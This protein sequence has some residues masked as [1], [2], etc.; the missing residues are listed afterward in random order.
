MAIRF[1]ITGGTWSSTSTWNDGATLG[2]PTSADDVY[3]NNRIVNIDTSFNV[4]SLNN[5]G[6]LPLVSLP[7]IPPMTTNSL[8][9]GF[10]TASSGL[11][12]AYLAFNRDYSYFNGWFSTT[13]N[14]GW[15]SYQFPTGKI[16]KR[17]VIWGGGSMA[18]VSSNVWQPR[19]WTFEGSNDGSTWTI[20]ETVSN[21]GMPYQ[22]YYASGILPNVT[23]FTYYRV[24]VTNTQGGSNVPIISEIEMTE[25]TESLGGAA[26]G[27]FNFNTAGVTA[28]ITG[29]TPISMGTATLFSTTHSGGTITLNIP[30]PITFSS[31]N[32]FLNFTGNGDLVINT[33]SLT[34]TNT[35]TSGASYIIKSGGGTL[36]FI[37]NVNGIVGSTNAGNGPFYVFL[38][39][40]GTVNITGN[41]NGHTNTT[42]SIPQTIRLTTGTVNIVGQVT[43]PPAQGSNIRTIEVVA[44]TVN[45]TGNVNGGVGT[46]INSTGTLINI[47]GGV[48]G[49]TSATNVAST[50]TITVIGNVIASTNPAIGLTAANTINIIGNVTASATN[51]G[52]QS[53]STSSAVNVTGNLQNTNGRQAIW[54]PR[55]FISNSSTTQWRLF[56]NAGNNKTLYSTDTFPNLPSIGDVRNGSV[57]GPASGLTGTLRMAIPSD[58]RINVPTDNTVGSATL[59]SEDLFNAILSGS[60]NPVAIRLR[61]ISTVQTT[62]DQISS[63][64]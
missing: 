11:G 56:D 40:N 36:T 38:I 10:V 12:S 9:S 21:F 51:N 37:G 39:S 2:I 34:P 48:S 64:N 3:T 8:P 24:N 61:N 29:A 17:Y 50:G 13:I 42:S 45:I 63:Y 31:N 23:S 35:G 47:T 30:S 15:I 32:T 52:I 5:T 53:T 1:A 26:G 55:V 44:G 18:Q 14:T 58:V 7:A 54:C 33:Q 6:F 43:A 16:I 46:A 4:S 22:S 27:S 19:S 62:G 59:T 25:S 20:L 60:T 57:Y 28:N 49:S 41:V